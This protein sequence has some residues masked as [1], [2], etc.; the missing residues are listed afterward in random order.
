M[1]ERYVEQLPAIYPAVLDKAVKKSA[2]DIAM[3]T[4]SELK[5]AEEL[6]QL[7]SPLKT[8]TDLLS[9]ETSPTSSMILPL[10]TMILKS[11]APG[12]EDS[13]TIREAKAAVTQD[14]ER[15]YADPA[16][17][18][19]LHRATALD[20]RFKSLPFLHEARCDRVV[21]GTSVTSERVFS[22]AGDIVSAS[23]YVG[24]RALNDRQPQGSQSSTSEWIQFFKDAGIPPS[25]AVT[26]ALSF[27]DNRYMTGTLEVGGSSHS[28][29]T[30]AV[31]PLS[32]ALN[33]TLLP[34]GIGP[35]FA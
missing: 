6:I 23:R 34:G 32:K 25:L 7:L 31:G 1:L 28:K 18:D 5:L 12:P 14:L 4:D 24:L 17:L 8:M 2:K 26:Y 20:P 11:M 27:V 9:S 22:T 16:L 33:P 21:P 35:W 3:L 29:N 10:K 13:A 15:R 19:Y 30:I